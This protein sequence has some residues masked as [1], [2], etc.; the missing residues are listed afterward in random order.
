[1]VKI[2]IYAIINYIFMLFIFFLS[3]FVQPL[4]T[5]RPIDTTELG[6]FISI[7]DE[8]LQNAQSPREVIDEGS[9]KITFTNEEH[10]E[11]VDFPI[12]FT[13]DGINNSVNDAHKQKELFPIEDI[14]EGR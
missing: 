13:V 2:V 12:N 5:Y 3:N 9:S 6:K 14:R 11:N 8:H 7:S 4:K 1:M 10:A